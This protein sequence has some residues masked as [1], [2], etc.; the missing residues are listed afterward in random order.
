MPGADAQHVLLVEPLLDPA[1]QA[2]AVGRVHRIGQTRPTQVLFSPLSDRQPCSCPS[3]LQQTSGP[4]SPITG[5]H[6]EY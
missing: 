6:Y 4:F 1:V 2:Q 5:S 3:I